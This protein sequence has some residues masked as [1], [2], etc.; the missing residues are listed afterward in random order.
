MAVDN[1]RI[2]TVRTLHAAFVITI[3]LVV[4]ICP[5]PDFDGHRPCGCCWYCRR[6]CAASEIPIRERQHF[7]RWRK[8]EKGT[9]SLVYGQ[10]CFAYACR[11]RD[12]LRFGFEVLGSKLEH[13]WAVLCSRAGG[14]TDLGAPN[15]W[16]GHRSAPHPPIRQES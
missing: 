10:H 13:C 2:S 12:A 9:G 4:L 3:F 11:S 14:N 6:F 16:L 1:D 15:A 8:S 7:H 5:K